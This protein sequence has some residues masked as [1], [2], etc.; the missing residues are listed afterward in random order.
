MLLLLLLLTTTTIVRSLEQDQSIVHLKDGDIQG[1]IYEN[2]RAFYGIPYA[3]PPINELRWA[4]AVPAKPWKGILSTKSY[5]PGCP[6]ICGMP[7]AMCPKETSEDCLFLDVYA[8]QAESTKDKPFPVMFYIYGGGGTVGA[9]GVEALNA[10]QYS[11]RSKM[12]VVNHNYRLGFLANLALKNTTG[13]L[14][15]R[16]HLHA[17]KW[18]RDNIKAFGGD[19][20]RV[21]IFGQ[22]SG[23]SSVE[24]LLDEPMANGLFHQAIVASAMDTRKMTLKE[25]QLVSKEAAKSFKCEIDDLVCLRAIPADQTAPTRGRLWMPVTEKG[26]GRNLDHA[27]TN[28]VPMIFGSTS[29]EASFF[30]YTISKELSYHEYQKMVSDL[31]GAENTSRALELYPSSLHG[32]ARPSMSKIFTD[33]T[34]TCPARRRLISRT[35]ANLPTYH[36]LYNYPLRMDHRIINCVGIACHGTDANLFMSFQENFQ[37]KEFY[38]SNEMVSYYS[39]FVVNGDPNVGLPVDSEWPEYSASKLTLIFNSPTKVDNFSDNPDCDLLDQTP[40]A[41]PME[42]DDPSIVRLKDGDIQGVIYENSRAFYGVGG[43]NPFRPSPGKEYCQLSYT[44][45]D[46]PSY[47]QWH[48]EYKPYPV[49]FYIYGGGG[50]AGAGGVEG[51]NATH[52]SSR[53]KMIVVN[54]N[55]RLGLLANLA[56]ANTTGDLTLKDHLLALKWVRDNI[57][58]FGGDPNR[59]TIFGQSSGAS[60]VEWLLDEPMANG[61]FHQAVIISAS[62][63]RKQTLQERRI[64]TI[65]VAE[66]LKCDIDDM[67]CLRSRPFKMFAPII[68]S[69]WMPVTEKGDG[70]TLDDA[71]TNRVPIMFGNTAND[72]AFFVYTF[73]DKMTYEKYQMVVSGMF[74]ADNSSRVLERYPSSL[75]GDAGPSL[76]KLWT[77]ILFTCPARRRLIARSKANLTS[78]HYK[79]TYPLRADHRVQFCVG[80]ACHGTDVNYIMSFSKYINFVEKERY[81]SNEMVSYYSNFVVNGDPNVG[82]PVDSEW[83]EYSASKLTMI[84]NSPTQVDNLSDNPDCDLLDQVYTR[85]WGSEKALLATIASH[86]DDPRYHF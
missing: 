69:L 23:A 59:V 30:T 3:T 61:L 80:I 64:T 52:Y 44:H 6:Q 34:F 53:S 73:R 62:D 7:P 1:V 17:L 65:P 12:I 28:R 50:T 76:A 60:S 74:G 86:K 66:V 18:V 75:Q 45:L 54:H 19:P 39:N 27:Y 38:L 33:A 51:L 42:Q 26:D 46:A 36:Y 24:W 63:V 22:S 9:S 10:T 70:H 84:F 2:S 29:E 40:L 77:D 5:A 4:E 43:L 78:Y 35:K 55:Y 82:L 21:T 25:R 14:T 67:V 16:D 13:D 85:K 81:L 20:N 56:L 71:Y 37:A 72:F 32:D 68:S 15:L 79:F 57:E 47:A 11:S 83:P 41:T 31:V 49:M 8:P 48:L 58:A